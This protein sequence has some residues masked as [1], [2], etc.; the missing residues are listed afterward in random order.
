VAD[1]IPV[2]AI[3]A[4]VFVLVLLNLIETKSID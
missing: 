2:Y 4:F 1:W 3:L